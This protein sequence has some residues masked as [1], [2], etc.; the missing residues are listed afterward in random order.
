MLGGFTVKTIE[1]VYSTVK[2]YE[3][4]TAIITTLDRARLNELS[5]ARDLEAKDSDAAHD[6][7]EEVIHL[8]RNIS[9]TPLKG[10]EHSQSGKLLNE[11]IQYKEVFESY[12][13]LSI[14]YEVQRESMVLS[15][16]QADSVLDGFYAARVKQNEIARAN[17]NQL[18]IDSSE[19]A[20]NFS[21]VQLLS[22]SIDSASSNFEEYIAT[23]SRREYRRWQREMGLIN[24]YLQRLRLGMKDENSLDILQK[25]EDLTAIYSLSVNKVSRFQV[26]NDQQSTDQSIEEVRD[27]SYRLSQLAFNLRNSEAQVFERVQSQLA[28]SQRDV[29]RGSEV[30]QTLYAFIKQIDRARQLERD[31]S[32]A[33][34]QSSKTVHAT[35]VSAILKL[36][37]ERL[38][39]YDRE[40][41]SLQEINNVEEFKTLLARYSESFEEFEQTDNELQK[42]TARMVAIAVATE[43]LLKSMRD[44]SFE[45]MTVARDNT[46]YVYFLG[47]GFVLAIVWLGFL[48]KRAN[49]QFKGLIDELKLANDKLKAA[50][51]AKS[52]FLANMSHEI[53]TPM[54]AIIGLT[55]L[56]KQTDDQL[57]Q[58]QYV[59][60]VG[61]SANY[62]L[63]I[64][65]DILDVSKIEAGKLELEESLF[66]LQEVID[67]TLLILKEQ[68]SKKDLELIIHLSRSVPNEVVGDALR[69]KQV[70]INLGS[71]AIKFTESGYVH[72]N[73]ELGKGS[74]ESDK[75][76]ISFSVTDSGIGMTEQQQAKLFNSFSQADTSTT[77][78]YGGTGLGLVICQSIIAKMGGSINVQSKK[79]EGSTFS[80][81]LE[82]AKPSKTVTINRS[83]DTDLILIDSN[84][85]SNRALHSQIAPYT[86]RFASFSSIAEFLEGHSE[87]LNASSVILYR[88]N[89]SSSLEVNLYS[90]REIEKAMRSVGC[91]F[92]IVTYLNCSK[93]LDLMSSSGMEFK[94]QIIEL[95]LTSAQVTQYANWLS[96]PNVDTGFV[97]GDTSHYLEDDSHQDLPAFFAELVYRRVL[98]VED[99]EINQEL[100][101]NFLASYHISF[102]IAENGKEALLNLEKE[103]FDIVL[104]DCHMPVLD[105]YQTTEIIRTKQ[106]YKDLPIIALTADVFAENAERIGECGMNALIGKPFVFDELSKKMAELM[107][108]RQEVMSRVNLLQLAMRDECG[109][110]LDSALS[111][112]SGNVDLYLQLLS[113]FL[114]EFNETDFDIAEEQDLRRYIHKVKGVVGNIGFQS[115]YQLCKQIESSEGGIS[116]MQVN[117]LKKKLVQSQSIAQRVIKLDE[118]NTAII[119]R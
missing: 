18:R 96:E 60:K 43:A 107:I 75:C 66:S 94:R 4:V 112:L 58:K 16:R 22:N 82:F 109:L 45:H 37:K 116:P 65:N 1:N 41:L 64:I 35:E 92:Y 36:L 113:K 59:S 72:I 44:Q 14:D 20:E 118:R 73:I 83:S 84:E 85:H 93:V 3:H 23:G 57:V 32:I 49:H 62:L 71:N 106:D 79:G 8:A 97:E 88:W 15:A 115:M 53:R 69:L 98:V 110:D 12:V 11:L 102:S 77:R 101:A 108:T 28:D 6:A 39:S 7:I 19:V 74:L 27:F 87:V 78:N 89:Q 105:G 46:L 30:E 42:S 21:I 76:F 80:Y 103:T 68:A 54:N 31:Y 13:R 70:L 29:L 117:D 2:R 63:S 50:N 81:S 5:F 52:S 95:P 10:G 91:R 26:E 86:R 51:E 114:Y 17:T 48:V 34:Y 25:I 33:R 61:H 67:G 40:K 55:Q 9:D 38:E 111:K 99:N 104:M 90:I 56:A 119:N 24:G 100:I 47:T